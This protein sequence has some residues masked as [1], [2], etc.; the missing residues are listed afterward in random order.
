MAENNTDLIQTI[1]HPRREGGKLPMLTA[2]SSHFGLSPKQ[3]NEMFC[4][5]FSIFVCCYICELNTLLVLPN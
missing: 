3:E 4:K 1:L 5:H 2:M